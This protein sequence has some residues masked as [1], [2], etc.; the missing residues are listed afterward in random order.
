[1]ILILYNAETQSQTTTKIVQ[2]MF[3]TGY[4]FESVLCKI[5]IEFLM[6]PGRVINSEG[7]PGDDLIVGN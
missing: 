6:G 4:N 5:S 7:I 2:Q 1:M 3:D